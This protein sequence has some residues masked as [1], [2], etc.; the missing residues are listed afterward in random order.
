MKI[1]VEKLLKVQDE[2]VDPPIML[3]ANHFRLKYDENSQLFMSLQ[4]N[5]NLLNN[6][7]LDSGV[8]GNIMSLKV[9]R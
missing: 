6:C 9:T 7:I 4:V 2:P 8:G 1:K 3:Q 5:N